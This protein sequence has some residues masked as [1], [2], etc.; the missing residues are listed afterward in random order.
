MLCFL[1]KILFCDNEFEGFEEARGAPEQYVGRPLEGL[2]HLKADFLGL[3]SWFTIDDIDFGAYDVIWI[4]LGHREMQPAWYVYP[5]LIRHEAPNAKIVFNVDYEGYF[6]NR[7]LDLR[8]K[9]AWECADVMHVV[10]KLGERFFTKH[11]SIP[12]VHDH[13]GRPHAGGIKA[14]PPVPLYKR[15]G[16]VF[17]RHTNIPEILTELE[18]IKKSR[19]KAIGIDS[20]PPPFSFG[21]YL[22]Y[23]ADAFKLKGEFYPRLPFNQYLKVISKAYVGICNHVGISRFAWECMECGIPVIHSEYSEWG[24]ILYPN[25]TVKHNDVASFLGMIKELR[26]NNDNTQLFIWQA[27][28]IAEEKYSLKACEGRV[29]SFLKVLLE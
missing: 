21:K 18:V 17:T 6:H 24:N 9:H 5:R 7:K 1:L 10:T 23:M 22:K 20:V 25:L 12:V 16:V 14:P 15:H 19:M 2:A 4:Y 27:Q 8:F 11:L 13:L 3:K 26:K 29:D 28:G